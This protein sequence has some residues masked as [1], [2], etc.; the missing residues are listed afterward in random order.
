MR[1]FL[2]VWLLLLGAGEAVSADTPAPLRIATYNASLND[3]EGRLATNLRQGLPAARSAAAILQRVR[4]DIVLINE[5]DHDPEGL[6]AGIFLQQYL[7]I[8]QAGDA[9][10]EYPHYY[11]GPVNT[12]VPSGVDVNGD[13]KVEGPNDAFGFGRHPGQFGMLLLSRYP[14]D[15][16][17][18]RSFRLLPWSALPDARRPRY[19]DGRAFHTDTVWES[20]RLSS[21]AHWDAQIATPLG[22]VHVL[23]AHPTPPVFDGPEDL[24]G[25][26][27]FDELRLWNLYLSGGD[28]P[29]LRDDQGRPGGLPEHASF[30]V[31]GD[32][33]ADPLDGDTLTGAVLQ[34]S[35]HPRVR[36]YPAPRS[37]GARQAAKSDQGPP[38]RTEPATHTAQFEH[39]TGN[40]RVDYVLPSVDFDVV[41]SGVFWPKAEDAAAAWLAGSDHRLVW[42]DLRRAERK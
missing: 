13:G 24:N 19:P 32:L 12:G 28:L 37:E 33:N 20:L 39:R 34:V 1:V 3:N 25:R 36:Q 11:A 14:I 26:R 29:W 42:V 38:K 4:P 2:I 30:V 8:S 5:F 40:M 17:T 31:L 7:G 16:A 27:N 18:L 9:P 6:A 15:M 41:D 22:P 10:L 23:A 35:G 21:K